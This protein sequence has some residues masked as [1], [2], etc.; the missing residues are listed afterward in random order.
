MKEQW[1]DFEFNDRIYKVSNFG[2][3]IGASGKLLKTRLNKDGYLIVTLGSKKHRTAKAVHRLVAE[4]FVKNPNNL[5]EVNHKDFNR[6]NPR[7]DNL[8]WTTHKENIEY[9]TKNKHYK[10]IKIGLKNPN[11]K[12][13]EQQAKQIL[14]LY[15]S[16][17]SIASIARKYDCG[18]TTIQHIIKG[19]TWRNVN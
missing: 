6:A 12:L 7:Y 15:K 9:S 2:N 4:L 3:I 17:Y 19:D 5:P 18:W 11:A 13:N 1:E 16:K 10:D 14:Y 8:E